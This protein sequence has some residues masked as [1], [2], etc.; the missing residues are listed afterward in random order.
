MS[1]N[2]PLAPTI[3]ADMQETNAFL[4]NSS[5]SKLKESLTELLTLNKILTQIGVNSELTQK[6][7][8]ALGESSFDIAGKYGKMQVNILAPYW[9]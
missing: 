6:Q 8:L 2:K 1:D 7:L 3:E 5:F 9:K 4:S